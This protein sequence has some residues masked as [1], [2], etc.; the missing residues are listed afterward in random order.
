MFITISYK[1]K[2]TLPNNPT[3]GSWLY[4]DISKKIVKS[5]AIKNNVDGI[6]NKDILYAII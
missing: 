6:I 5:T 2:N 4:Y 1:N 3:V